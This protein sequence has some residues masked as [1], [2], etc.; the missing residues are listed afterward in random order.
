M[1][2]IIEKLVFYEKVNVEACNAVLSLTFKEYFKFFPND[3]DELTGIEMNDK[4]YFTQVK[5]YCKLQKDNKY[6]KKVEYARAN[7]GKD[8]IG[9]FYANCGIQN[10]GGNLRK[11]LTQGIYYDYDINNCHPTILLKMCK[12]RNMACLYLEAYC[13]DRKAFLQ[14]VNI[15]KITM[16]KFFN[17]DSPK[18]KNYHTAVISLIKEV[19]DNKRTLFEE[20]KDTV[21]YNNTKGNPISS[22]INKIWCEK[23]NEL[24]QNAI[25][26]L[27]KLI[28]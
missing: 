26:K 1:A 19:N 13:K 21:Q 8:T 4:S 3:K 2:T 16:L 15:D 11:Y 25:K 22:C 17:Q 6:K 10:L 20:M 23:E 24:L 14:K 9:R 7:D 27:I 28:F 18:V 5:K 12:E